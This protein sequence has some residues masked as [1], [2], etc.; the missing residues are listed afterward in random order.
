M[1]SLSDCLQTQLSST[2]PQLTTSS[3]KYFLLNY[4]ILE[5]RSFAHPTDQSCR[6][7]YNDLQRMKTSISSV[8]KE[9]LLY[10]SCQ[11][12]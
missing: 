5:S 8:P 1:N 7:I 12:T 4:H 9:R 6:N 3:S 2:P 10:P 11:L